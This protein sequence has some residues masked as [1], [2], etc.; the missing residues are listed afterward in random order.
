MNAEEYLATQRVTAAVS[1]PT[2]A[3]QEIRELKARIAELEAALTGMVDH[4]VDLVE[5]GDCGH[6]DAEVETP[7]KSARAAL[8]EKT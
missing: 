7:V 2:S 5:C 8:K 3:L 1:T 4:Y 6:W